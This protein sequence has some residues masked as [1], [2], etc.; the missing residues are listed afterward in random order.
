MSG[1]VWE[2]EETV[3]MTTVVSWNIAKRREVWRELV[4]MGA[5]VALLQEPGSPP[6]DVADRVGTGPWEHCDSHLWNSQRWEGR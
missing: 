6:G 1:V 3:M 2:N 5:D 4:D